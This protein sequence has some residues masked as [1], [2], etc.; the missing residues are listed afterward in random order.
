M[1]NGS[2]RRRAGRRSRDAQ[3]HALGPRAV[4]RVARQRRLFR[5]GNGTPRANRTPAQRQAIA[6]VAGW[7]HPFRRRNTPR[8]AAN[9]RGGRRRDER[10]GHADCMPAA[11]RRP[12]RTTVRH[13]TCRLPAAA[14]FAASVAL[15]ACALIVAAGGPAT[16]SARRERPPVAFAVEASL[17]RPEGAIALPPEPPTPPV[18]VEA[19][20]SPPTATAGGEIAETSTSEPP[21]T[22]EP[23]LAGDHAPMPHFDDRMRCVFARIKASAPPPPAAAATTETAADPIA[24][25]QPPPTAAAPVGGAFRPEVPSPLPGENPAP[26]YPE[27]ARLRRVQGTVVLRL[28]VDAAGRVAACEVGSSSGSSLLDAAA[29]RAATRWRFDRGPGVVEQPFTFR[30]AAP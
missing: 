24:A 21:A 23:D 2:D 30:L 14:A 4:D 17:L 27:S 5:R 6:R 12:V 20:E 7:R 18:V 15:H 22:A 29:R 11:V 1:A 25:P 19:E 26:D 13:A 9:A 3:D 16:A 10:A 8:V 28:S